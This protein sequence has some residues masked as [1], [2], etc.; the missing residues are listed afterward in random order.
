M[1]GETA[2]HTTAGFLYQKN[3]AYQGKIAL[4]SGPFRMTSH[5]DRVEAF[6]QVME[7][8]YPRRRFWCRSVW[9]V[10]RR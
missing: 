3:G 8:E 2:A 5:Q 9:R 10:Q 4:L 7:T 1:I 6:M